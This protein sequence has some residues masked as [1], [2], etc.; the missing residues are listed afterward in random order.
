MVDSLKLKGKIVESG[1]SRKEIS[2]KMGISEHTLH[3]KING[4]TP[5]MADEA[6]VLA[7]ILGIAHD[8]TPYFFAS[9][10]AETATRR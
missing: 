1:L 8:M 3:N 2:T 5:F 7:D 9:E 6:F 4:I 10:V